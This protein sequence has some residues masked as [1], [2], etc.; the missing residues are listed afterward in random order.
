VN[1]GRLRE[2]AAL[3]LIGTRAER[4]LRWVRSLRHVVDRHRHPEWN[5]VRDE[6]YAIDQLLKRVIEPSMNCIDIGCHLG[7]VLSGMERYASQGRHMAFEPTPYKFAWLKRKYPNV[8]L[9]QMALSDKAGDVEFF[10][11]TDNSGFS[12]LRSHRRAN[13]QTETYVVKCA[14][15]DDVAGERDVGFIKMDVEG[16]EPLVI[17]GAEALLRRSRPHI[18]FECTLSGLQL[19]DWKPEA[20][21]DLICKEHGYNIFLI[22]DWLDDKPALTVAGFVSAMSFPAQAFNFFATAR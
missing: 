8:D 15:L 2:R 9:R 1:I 22:R 16:A 3:Q 12:G 18:L 13:W 14:R 17:R 21:F 19:F 7:S 10:Y 20:V 4:P 5:S 6:D 11:Q